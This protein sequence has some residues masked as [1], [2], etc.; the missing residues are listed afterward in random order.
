MNKDALDFSQN[1][2]RTFLTQSILTITTHDLR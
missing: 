1:A 2:F